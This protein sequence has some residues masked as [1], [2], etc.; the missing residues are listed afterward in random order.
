MLTPELLSV[1]WCVT[2]A[3]LIF[4]AVKKKLKIYKNEEHVQAPES[5]WVHVGAMSETS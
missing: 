3:N 5:L 1:L 2:I 4:I